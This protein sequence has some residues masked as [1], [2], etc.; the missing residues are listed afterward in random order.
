MKLPPEKCWKPPLCCRNF[1]SGEMKKIPFCD[2]NGHP[3]NYFV[4]P[5][6]PNMFGKEF[7]P[8]RCVE[9][10]PIRRM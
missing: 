6:C 2:G 1:R 3:I 10:Y 9:T 5:T 8:A 4:E 7:A